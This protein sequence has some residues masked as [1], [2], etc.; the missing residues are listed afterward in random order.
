LQGKFPK[1]IPQN[2]GNKKKKMLVILINEFEKQWIDDFLINENGQFNLNITYQKSGLKIQLYKTLNMIYTNN[3]EVCMT[4]I[5]Y[6]SLNP[7]TLIYVLTFLEYQR[8]DYK[9]RS[10][11]QKGNSF[12]AISNEIS[13][14]KKYLSNFDNFFSIRLNLYLN[15]RK[16]IIKHGLQFLCSLI[17]SFN[18]IEM[19]YNLISKLMD[20]YKDWL[21]WLSKI[22]NYISKFKR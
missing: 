12:V 10:L 13:N 2:V 18:D 11:D 17:S 19:F 8:E 3:N 20:L 6:K 22:I 4:T 1:A 16:K 21:F 14:K 9:N 15:D 5:D 7:I